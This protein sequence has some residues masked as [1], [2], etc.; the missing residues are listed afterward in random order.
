VPQV[1][2]G[3][4]T[5]SQRAL[6]AV[7]AEEIEQLHAEGHFPAGS[8]GPKIEAAIHFL[9]HGGRRA[10]I[11]DAPNLPRA[12]DGAAGTHIIGRL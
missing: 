3:F 5:P 1:Y 2:V 9:R 8:M 4:N 7:T 10:L 6:S 12:L 11:T